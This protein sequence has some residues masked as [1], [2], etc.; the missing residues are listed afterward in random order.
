[1]AT[2][3]RKIQKGKQTAASKK[4]QSTKKKNRTSALFL[5]SMLFGFLIVILF[6]NVSVSSEEDFIRSD[7]KWTLVDGIVLSITPIESASQRLDGGS[8]FISAY[9][10]KYSYVVDEETFTKEAFIKK[11]GNETFIKSISAGSICRVY[12]NPEEGTSYLDKNL[13]SLNGE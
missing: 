10:V 12:L 3:L 1:M 8:A 2:K 4:T 13:E 11:G 9:N 6:N 7:P 5:I